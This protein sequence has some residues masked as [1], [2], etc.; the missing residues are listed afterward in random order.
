VNLTIQNQTKSEHI[1]LQ[2]F[3]SMGATLFAYLMFGGFVRAYVFQLSLKNA[4]PF[5]Y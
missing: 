3:H 1:F 2:P 5:S 4:A